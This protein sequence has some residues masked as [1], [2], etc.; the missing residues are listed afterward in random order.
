MGIGRFTSQDDDQLRDKETGDPV[1]LVRLL[2]LDLDAGGLDQVARQR[3]DYLRTRTTPHTVV[4]LF[5]RRSP[6]R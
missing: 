6:G 5:K 2:D 4:E 3:A 1:R